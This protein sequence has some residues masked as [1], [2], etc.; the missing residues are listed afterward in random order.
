MSP[1]T[2]AA[3][4]ESSDSLNEP[5]FAEVT[6]APDVDATEMG[7]ESWGGK[8]KD[9]AVPLW[10]ASDGIDLCGRSEGVSGRVGVGVTCACRERERRRGVVD[11]SKF[12]CSILARPWGFR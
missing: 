5:G 2:D 10:R 8:G 4:L 12:D 3:E 6:V 9:G 1:A 7:M 11:I